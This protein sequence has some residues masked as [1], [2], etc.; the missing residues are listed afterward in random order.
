MIR[1][2][3]A[4]H[5]RS[6]GSQEIAPGDSGFG[7]GRARRDA[8]SG[9]RGVFGPVP[10]P[11]WMRRVGATAGPTGSRSLRGTR[12]LPSVNAAASAR[13]GSV[14]IGANLRRLPAPSRRE[15]ARDGWIS[16]VLLFH[17]ASEEP[18]GPTSRLDRARAGLFERSGRDVPRARDQQ[19]FANVLKDAHFEARA[20]TG[21]VVEQRGVDSVSLPP[22]GPETPIS[23]SAPTRVSR[24]PAASSERRRRGAGGGRRQ[25]AAGPR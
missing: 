14:L 4:P 13:D 6:P 2:R 24:Y 7:T 17:S 20:S 9:C 11:L 5:L 10:R 23:F 25:T 18:P 21:V 22:H 8:D 12:A 16:L 15:G 3:G 19:R 1:R